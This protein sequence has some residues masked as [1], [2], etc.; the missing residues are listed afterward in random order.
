MAEKK[1]KSHLKQKIS[2]KSRHLSQDQGIPSLLILELHIAADYSLID[3]PLSSISDMLLLVNIE[4]ENPAA[5]YSPADELQ[6]HQR[7]SVSLSCS[8]WERVFPLLYDHRTIHRLP[9]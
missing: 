3:S 6:Y 7:R 9:P 4:K 5:P 1:T 8:G 2:S